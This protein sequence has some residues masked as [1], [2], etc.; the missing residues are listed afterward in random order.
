MQ[1][2]EVEASEC[3]RW[4]RGAPSAVL[5]ELPHA[6]LPALEVVDF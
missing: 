2:R 1:V 5:T 6:D 4:G 3:A